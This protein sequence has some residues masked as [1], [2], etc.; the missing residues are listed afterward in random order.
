MFRIRPIWSFS[1]TNEGI[2]NPAHHKEQH[3]KHGATL[4]DYS[5]A[6]DGG[7]NTYI[8]YVFN[9]ESVPPPTVIIPSP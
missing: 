9:S 6:R 7:T 4:Q 3:V 5:M 8:W 2:M 1:F